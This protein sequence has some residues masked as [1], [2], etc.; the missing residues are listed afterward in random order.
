MLAPNQYDGEGGQEWCQLQEQLNGPRWDPGSAYP[1]TDQASEEGA[2][3]TLSAEA[4]LKGSR[5]CGKSWHPF[6][7]QDKPASGLPLTTA[8]CWEPEAGPHDSLLS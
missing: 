3:V 2:E 6:T 7:S 5:V 4:K 1:S 8:R